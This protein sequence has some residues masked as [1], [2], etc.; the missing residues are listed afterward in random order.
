LM[1]E[2]L[3]IMISSLASQTGSLAGASQA[4]RLP[5]GKCLALT[6]TR[7]LLINRCLAGQKKVRFGL[8]PLTQK[9]LPMSPNTCYPSSRSKQRGGR[10][11]LSGRNY[12]GQQVKSPKTAFRCYNSFAEKSKHRKG[13]GAYGT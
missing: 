9:V 2:K 10:A 5:P 3:R 4:S 11:V 12:F 1:K 13:L 7:R 8:A 6:P